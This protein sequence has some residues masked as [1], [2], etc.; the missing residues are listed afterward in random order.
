MEKLNKEQQQLLNE[1]SDEYSN[2]IVIY[3]PNNNVLSPQ[4]F[5]CAEFNRPTTN[6]PYYSLHGYK[7]IT[8]IVDDN[9]MYTNLNNQVKTVITKIETIEAKMSTREFHKDFRY[10]KF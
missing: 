5:I 4:V 8:D 1:L 6:S 10:I 2:V 7:N 3:E 9:S